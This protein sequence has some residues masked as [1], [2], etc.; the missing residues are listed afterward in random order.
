MTLQEPQTI[1]GHFL[2]QSSFLAPGFSAYF[3]NPMF[4]DVVILAPDERRLHCHQVV[5][6]AGSRRF[7][8]LLEKGGHRLAQGRQQDT[9]QEFNIS[10][11]TSP[12][13][14]ALE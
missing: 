4:S 5:L 11:F 2:D 3:N 14:H 9:L 6:S 1:V 10:A 7:R 8:K 13:D 12:A